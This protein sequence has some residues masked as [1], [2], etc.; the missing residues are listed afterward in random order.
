MVIKTEKFGKLS[1]WT[2]RDPQGRITK[3]VYFN[4]RPVV[5]FNSDNIRER[6][7]AAVQLVEL[8]YCNQGKAGKICGFHRNTIYNL[9]R[10]KR[11]LG[12]EALFQDDRGPK[13]PRKYIGEIRT[14]IKKLQRKYPE[15]ID[16]Q[17]A[18]EAAKQLGT[19]VSAVLWP[20]SG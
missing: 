15:W 20:A 9:L 8:G 19:P 6:R 17:I 3:T 16:Q 13:S 11:L 5:S 4:Y 7:I 18:D 10:T 2:D 12:I 14:A 1:V